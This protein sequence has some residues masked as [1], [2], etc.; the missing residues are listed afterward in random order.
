MVDKS[1][2]RK[3]GNNLKQN[4]VKDI[5]S[6]YSLEEGAIQCLSKQMIKC[7]SRVAS[8]LVQTD[9]C[10][11]NMVFASISDLETVK[12]EL[13]IKISEVRNE[14]L[15]IMN[16]NNTTI[17]LFPDTAPSFNCSSSVSDVS[18]KSSQPQ[19]A[20]IVNSAVIV[21]ENSNFTHSCSINSSVLGQ[22]ANQPNVTES[23][24]DRHEPKGKIIIAG[25]S[26]LHRVNCRKMKVANIFTV[27]LT[28]GETVLLVQFLN[29]V[30][31][32]VNMPRN[33]WILLF[34]QERTILPDVMSLQKA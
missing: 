2:E 31:L 16:S 20:T 32:S 25:D 28:K 27:K 8:E 34:W 11:S 5:Y 33:T 13:T 17:P 1:I 18:L 29:H 15:S 9:N 12:S 26:L 19:V 30:I 22:D 10:L 23:V 14:I 3:S 4:L 7:D 24:L 6:L 21:E